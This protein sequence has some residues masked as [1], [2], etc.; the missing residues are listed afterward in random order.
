MTDYRAAYEA[1]T[2]HPVPPEAAG[3]DVLFAKISAG[4]PLPPRGQQA[5]DAG[6]TAHSLNDAKEAP[7][8]FHYYQW[9]LAH[10][11]AD[12][13]L[14]E[15]SAK[16]IGMAFTAANI[17]QTELPQPLTLNPWQIAA[18]ANYP[19]ATTKAVVVE[20][21][22]V[23][24][25]LHTLHPTWPLI[26]QGGNDFQKAYVALMQQLVARGLRLA[27]LGDL[28]S[29]GIRIADTLLGALPRDSG[30]DFLSLQTPQR[31]LQW[32]TDRGRVDAGRTGD[33]RISDPTLQTELATIRFS[34]KF[35]EQ[36][37][38][39]SEY[40]GLIGDWLKD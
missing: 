20:N 9:V 29:E 23:F 37:Q 22:G 35:V 25:L 26:D 17:F 15:L 24:V 16:L 2:G 7:A 39:L 14:N 40:E 1:A 32:I 31:V 34:G 11:F 12:G 28:D 13:Q 30:P 4:E 18:M 33:R 3:L 6:L 27:Y 21:N 36:E 19:L 38:L 10:Y 5:V 8:V